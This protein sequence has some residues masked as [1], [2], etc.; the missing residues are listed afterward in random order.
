MESEVVSMK[1]TP[2]LIDR[3]VFCDD[4]G[5]FENI[6]LNFPD[7][8]FEGKRIYTCSNFE[9]GFV[10][11]FHYHE[12]EAKIFICLKGAVK[13]VL[14][15]GC[16]KTQDTVNIDPVIF[17]I[18][19]KLQKGIYIPPNYANG[20]QSLTEDTVLLGLSNRTVDESRGDDIRFSPI[21]YA[22]GVPGRNIRDLWKTKW[23]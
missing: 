15:R 10:R 9:R 18:T 17:T 20:W 14:F 4:R 5:Y 16:K 6:P 13:F 19:D 7:L 2:V 21:A 8:E 1:D 3:S 12:H 22:I 23:R 11:A